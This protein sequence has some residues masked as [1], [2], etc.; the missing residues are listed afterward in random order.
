MHSTRRLRFKEQKWRS[1]TAL[2][3]PFLD[4]H[5]VPAPLLPHC[6][7]H[8]SLQSCRGPWLVTEY[9]RLPHCFT[10]CIPQPSAWQ[11]EDSIQPSVY[12]ELPPL[13]PVPLLTWGFFSF[14]APKTNSAFLCLESAHPLAMSAGHTARFEFSCGLQKPPSPLR[15]QG[16]SANWPGLN[17]LHLKLLPFEFSCWSKETNPAE[18]PA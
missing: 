10:T 3:H 15:W 6:L 12:T 7:R 9:T 18:K 14:L 5:Y 4:P 8:C 13:M 2:W 16:T 11:L 1:H 17:F